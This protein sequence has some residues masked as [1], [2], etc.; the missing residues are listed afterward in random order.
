MSILLPSLISIMYLRQP[1]SPNTVPSEDYLV[2]RVLSEQSMRTF[3][4]TLHEQI[5][6]FLGKLSRPNGTSVNMTPTLRY[7]GLNNI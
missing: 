5:N 7:L 1:A 2:S 6:I 4:E 3:K